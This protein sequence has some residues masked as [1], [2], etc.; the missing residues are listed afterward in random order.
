MGG[1]VKSTYVHALIALSWHWGADPAK[2]VE[3][4]TKHYPPANG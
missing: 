4:Y 3:I 1:N 2:M